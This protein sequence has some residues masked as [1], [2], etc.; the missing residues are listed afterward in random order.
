VSRSRA[1]GT[2]AETQVVAYLQSVGFI[3]AERR[4][5]SGRK[6]RGDVAGVPS[7]VIE[8]KN[9]IA[10]QLAEWV[11]EAGIERDNDNAAWG[12]VWHKKRG[13]AFPGQWYVTTTGEDF[14][15]LLRSALGIED[16]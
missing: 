10:T 8:I 9:D 5:L 12:V 6:D 15:K 4:A 11:K 2:A 7:T 14:V 16:A 1:K 13:A 3:H